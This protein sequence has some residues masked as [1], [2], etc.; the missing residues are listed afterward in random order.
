MCCGWGFGLKEGKGGQTH[1]GSNG[2]AQRS[3][4]VSR[5]SRGRPHLTI[6]GRSQIGGLKNNTIV[7]V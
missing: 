5:V 7:K 2:G 6:L 4:T 3:S 1:G